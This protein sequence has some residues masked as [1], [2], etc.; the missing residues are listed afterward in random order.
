MQQPV[1]VTKRTSLW[2][3]GGVASASAA[4]CTHPLDLLKVC[5]YSHSPNLKILFGRTA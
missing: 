2:Y 5:M 1:D 4:V 3:H